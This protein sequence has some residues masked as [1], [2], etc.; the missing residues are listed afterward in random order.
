M[1]MADKG[2]VLEDI[3][4]VPEE[5]IAPSVLDERLAHADTPFVIR[6]LASDWPLVKAAMQS[7]DAAKE[8]LLT[9]ARDRLF[10]ANIGKVAGERRVFYADDMRMNF[11][12]V[13]GPLDE[14]LGAMDTSDPHTAKLVY[15]SSIDMRDYFS[16]LADENS[17]PMAD[18]KPLESIWIGNQTVIAAHNDMMQNIAICAAG[19]RQFT[20]FPPDQ[21]ANLYIGP[22]DNTPAGRPVSMVDFAEPD[23]TKFPKFKEALRNSFTCEL[24]PGDA[25]FIPAMWWHHVK[26]LSPFNILVNYWWRDCPHFIGGGEEALLHA[27]LAV[28]DLPEV[29]KKQWQA[30]FAHYVFAPNNELT[31][32][33]PESGR[34]I[35]APLTAETAAQIKA[36]LL[37]SLSR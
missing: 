10:P 5:R 34:G 17:L 12:M 4:P 22:L 26:G 29:T 19:K 11:E 2:V 37:R 23:F 1:A 35:L 9:H 8:Y 27:I 18:R 14:F 21:F 24:E 15:L 32:H 7:D 25:V 3:S 31:A 30:L 16:T 20:L 36:R 28:R 6:G 13:Q 33:I